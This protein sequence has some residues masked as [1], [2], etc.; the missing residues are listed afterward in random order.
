LEF[1]EKTAA[2]AAHILKTD[3]KNGLDE[4][5]AEKR[6]LTYGKNK[7]SDKKKKSFIRR[8]FEQFNDFMIIILLAAAAVSFLTSFFAGSADITEALIIL[9]IVTLNA[10]LGTIQEIRA[11]N[12]LD[13]LKKL[14]SPHTLV[15]RGGKEYKINSEDIVPGDLIRIKAGDM[16]C[17]DCRLV[18]CDKLTADESA[19]TGESA[20]A[21]KDANIVHQPLTAPGDI[22]NMLMS[23]TCITGGTALAVAVKTGM[24]TEV[25]KIASM[26]SDTTPPQTPL[27]KRL[28]DTGKALGVAALVIC[29]IIF[30]IGTFKKIPP[31]EMFMTSVS[32][33]VAA[34]PEGLPAIVTIML[35][36]GLIRMSKH[37]AIVRNLPS[38]ETLGCATVIC[39]DK[40][41]TLTQNKMKA[42]AVSTRDERYFFEL[43]ILCSEEGKYINPTDSAIIEAAKQRGLDAAFYKHRYPQT[44]CIPF[45]SSRKRMCVKCGERT[46][47]K[48]ALEY[49]LPLCSRIRT[50]TGEITLTS[51]QKAKILYECD[52][53]TTH[54]LRVIACAYRNDK[55]SSEIKEYDL[56]FAGLIGISDPPR[57]EAAEAV[58]ACR[59]AGIRTIMITGDHAHTAAA[60]AKTTGIDTSTVLTG[61]QLDKM[62]DRQ[63]T[64]AVKTCC[65]YARVSPSHKSRIVEAL[66]KNGEVTAMT[67]DGVNDA[68][69]LKK[70]DI[71]CSMGINGTDVAK[72]ASDMILTDDNFAT[73]VYAV[74]EGRAI[75]DNIKKAVKFLLSSNIGEI[76]TV[77]FGI[78]FGCA[79]PLTAIE[80]LWVNLVTDSFPAIALGL[81]PAADDIMD[82]KPL[83][84]KKGIFSTGLWASI[85]FEGL[86]IGSLS[87]LAYELGLVLSKSITTARTMAFFVLS[88][89]QLVHAFNMRSEKSVICGG[90]FKNKYLVLSLI[91]GT[92]AQL[93]LIFISPAASLFNICPLNSTELALCFLL[94]VMPLVLVELQKAFN[95]KRS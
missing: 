27:Q 4:R 35:A 58:S 42:A 24:N 40:T 11:E 75:Y 88:V 92:A 30:I 5:E 38:V 6:L 16:V 64:E 20:A 8:F 43:C 21:E 14:S 74:R 68:P 13:A 70:A 23:S 90:L 9:A 91:I 78:I 25:G 65:V 48:G 45:D 73:I 44:D 39:T 3:L 49:I 57:P 60:V 7:L 15:I 69:A 54:A 89:S 31:L 18:E 93:A 32:L 67:G 33:A 47:V 36:L 87:L 29:G 83:D 22:K 77:L 12:S 80:L 71:G 55:S 2:E 59:R 81:D 34:I 84:P 46:I 66:S 94:S 41:G 95:R 17:A 1:Y 37:N 63:L 56:T 10:L 52:E 50:E 85:A 86:M 76:L 19:L 51:A 26:L 61:A 72:S 62:D 28:A 53:M 79:P 82:R